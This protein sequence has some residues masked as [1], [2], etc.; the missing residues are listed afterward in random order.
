VY[1]DYNGTITVSGTALVTSA[2]TSTTYGTI[3]CS[4]L[5]SS[6]TTNLTR[7]VI[8]G[9]TVQNTSPGTNGNAVYNASVGRVDISGGTIVAVT[10]AVQNTATSTTANTGAIILSG[11]PTITGRLRPSATGRLTVTTSFNPST[12]RLYTLDYAAYAAGNIAVI[13]GASSATNFTLHNQT[14]WK[15]SASGND[16]VIAAN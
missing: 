8:T 15:L 16:L 3:Y 9:G 4:T 10:Y 11:D 14:A 12:G 6:T 13:G 1:N 7:I 2:N 5:G